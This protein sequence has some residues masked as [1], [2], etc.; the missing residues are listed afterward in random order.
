MELL[1]EGAAPVAVPPPALGVIGVCVDTS[2][3]GETVVPVGPMIFVCERVAVVDM[4]AENAEGLMTVKA[5][6]AVV[7][8]AES[9]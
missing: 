1:V 9:V 5:R 8:R 2:L 3:L 4:M 6:A 7:W